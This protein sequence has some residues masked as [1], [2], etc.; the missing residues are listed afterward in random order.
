MSERSQPT[1]LFDIIGTCFSLEKPRH[2]LAKL[3]APDYALEMWF[4]QALRDSFAF[5]HA[6]AYLPLKDMLRAE[7]TRTALQLGLRPSDDDLRGVLGTFAELDPRPDLAAAV[8]VLADRSWQLLAL[9]MGA[10][11]STAAFSSGPASTIASAAC[12]HGTRSR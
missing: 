11:E 8:Q 1:A 12:S 4:A 5:S 9:T 10:S 3:G 6:G 7:L 2:S